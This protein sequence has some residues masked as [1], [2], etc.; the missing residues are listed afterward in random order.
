MEML[1][2]WTD[3]KDTL[4]LKTKVGVIPLEKRNGVIWMTQNEPEFF[5]QYSDRN[6]IAG[7]VNL[8]AVDI[9][10]DLPVEEVSTGNPM[11]IVPVKSLS[12]IQK[13]S[14]H[15]NNLKRF[16]K[17][18]K[19]L[20]PYL[21]TLETVDGASKIHTRFLA[22]HMNVMEDAATGSAAGPLIAYLLKYGVFGQNFDIQNEQGIEMGR[23]SKILM[24]GELKDDQY[25]IQ[26]GGSCVSV[27]MGKFTIG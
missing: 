4:K 16:F 22:P 23:P 15:V 21:F 27:G 3:K 18:K 1:D 26:V 19:C 17:D 6:E 11:L 7:L 13:A 12:G 8:S 9:R 14:G 10:N 20:A 24:K 5:N 2:I 25:K